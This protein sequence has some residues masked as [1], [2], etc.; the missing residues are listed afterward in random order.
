M[1]PRTLKQAVNGVATRAPVVVAMLQTPT[2]VW[3]AAGSALGSAAALGVVA[4]AVRGL[5]GRAALRP[6]WDRAAA[7]RLLRIGLPLG[8]VALLISLNSNL[9]RYFVEHYFGKAL[10]GAFAA[11]AY[12]LVAGTTVTA[13]LAQSCGPRLARNYADGDLRAFRRL[14]GK[15]MLIGAVLGLGALAVA[16]V[17]GRQVLTLLYRPEYAFAARSFAWLMAAGAVAYVA[18]FLNTAMV[19]VRAV[20]PQTYLFAVVI[21]VDFLACAALVPAYG[22]TG[23]AWG[24]GLAYCVQLAGAWFIVDAHLRRRQGPPAGEGAP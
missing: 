19:V 20:R 15:M 11:M 23:A 7:G 24:A 4:A 8:A 18:S 13:A 9:P 5:G 14:L 1:K 10:L 2:V 17:A 22:L 3:A 12:L 16:A 6:A 21:T